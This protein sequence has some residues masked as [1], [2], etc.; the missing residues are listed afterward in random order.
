MDRTRQ[1]DDADKE[2]QVPTSA[3][4]FIQ[5]CVQQIRA[6]VA[7]ADGDIGELS[8]AVVAMDLE[9]SRST[10]DDKRELQSAVRG[11]S[12]SLQALDRFHQRITNT[13][14]NLARLADF[15]R[16]MEPPFDEEAWQQFLTDAR[17][18]Y[19]MDAERIVFDSMFQCPDSKSEAEWQDERCSGLMIF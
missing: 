19:T 11:A 2:A 14:G 9:V 10:P 3:A 7:E 4:C 12:S 17:R 18:T 5:L 15:L 6:A 13:C 16:A 1:N 8:R